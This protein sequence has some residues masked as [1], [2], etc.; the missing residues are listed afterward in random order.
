MDERL[1]NLLSELNEYEVALTFAGVL[2]REFQTLSLEVVIENY[3]TL[4]SLVEENSPE[5]I[6]LDDL[7]RFYGEKNHSIDYVE[8]IQGFRTQIYRIM[9]DELVVESENSVEFN[10]YFFD[11]LNSF[12]NQ[13]QDEFD[14]KPEL[15][16]L[17]ALRL[18][19]A[20]PNSADQRA[21]LASISLD[22]LYLSTRVYNALIEEGINNMHSLSI[23]SPR[24]LI[25]IH[26]IGEEALKE[27][28]QTFRQYGF[29]LR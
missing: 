4:M 27:I 2:H 3:L 28:T 10:K 13:L 24:E 15:K 18:K 12:H 1:I 26:N 11:Q 17:N 16:Y 7:F 23:K 29:E 19:Y 22:E 14:G 5:Q 20:E 9:E 8:R 6:Y 21:V 25:G